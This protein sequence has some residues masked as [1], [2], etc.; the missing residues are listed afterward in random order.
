MK[1]AKGLYFGGN[2]A[3]LAQSLLST[4]V[5]ATMKTLGAKGP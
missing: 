3:V 5:T 2:N 1:G 4:D